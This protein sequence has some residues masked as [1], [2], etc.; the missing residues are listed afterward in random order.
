MSEYIGTVGTKIEV[1]V[2]YK[3]RFEY[4][5]HYTYYG[6]WHTI[7]IFEDVNGN[8][9]VWNTT[10]IV[11]DKKFID[12][13]GCCKVIY[14]NSKLLI[15][16][17]VKDHSEYKGT[18]QTVINRPRFKLLELA[19]SPY[20]IEMERKAEK[21][22]KKQEQIDSIT[23]ND[24][25]WEMPYSQYK[26]HYSDCETL[27]DSYDNHTDERGNRHGTPTITV[28]IREGRLKNS[29]VRGK[30]YAGYEFTSDS[31]EKVCYYAISEETAR[32]RMKKEFPNSDDWECTRI[33][34]Y[35]KYN[36]I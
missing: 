14:L 6:E 4:Q 21:D 34:R 10:G 5:T 15:T 23:P 22:R 25:V 17:T 11:E 8:C 13:N 12:D 27:I 20:E 18:K 30:H 1:E 33:Y 19:K 29:G 24:I 35:N 26:E 32:K 9:I 28:I 3:K 2:I 36:R 31:G 16:A 7:Y